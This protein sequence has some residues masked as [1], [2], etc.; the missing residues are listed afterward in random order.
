MPVSLLIAI[1]V[2]LVLRLPTTAG[3]LLVVDV[4]TRI[5]WA[6]ASAVGV[7]LFAAGLGW[8]VSRS[9]RTRGYP[10]RNSQ[11]LFP[12]FTRITNWICLLA[13]LGTLWLLDWVRVVDWGLRARDVPLLEEFLILAPYLGARFL[14]WLGF[15]RAEMQLRSQSSWGDVAR[16]AARSFRRS[17][18]L[19]LPVALIYLPGRAQLRGRGI[20]TDE[21][22]LITFLGMSG[23]SVV[24]FLVAPVFVRIAWPTRTLPPGPLRDRLTSISQRLGFQCSDFLVWEA[25][26]SVV[27]AGVTG[28]LPWFR[29]VLLSEAMIE[30]LPSSEI[31]AVFGHEVGHHVLKHLPYFALFFLGTAGLSSLLASVIEKRVD[32]Y[33]RVEEWIGDPTLAEIYKAVLLLGIV[34][35]FLFSVFGVLSRR[36]ERQADLFGARVVSCG[37]CTCPPHWDPNEL[38]SRLDRIQKLCPVGANL[39]A[40]ALLD[41]ALHNGMTIETNEWR[42][43]SIAGRIAFLRQFGEQPEKER[44]FEM[45]TWRLKWAVLWGLAVA[46]LVAWASS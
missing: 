2:S 17:L 1:V 8:L 25:G 22:I 10:D 43:G 20:S 26:G 16:S 45:G 33:F 28:C 37:N 18:G 46:S 4:W 12:L 9:I 3:P 38:D 31:E 19:V 14:A 44:R 6:V 24:V 42:H 15:S 36:F 29:Y 41:V 39:M 30:R 7:G 11:R 23:M 5:A 21:T 34:C 32:P 40:N 27:N 35:L 13:F